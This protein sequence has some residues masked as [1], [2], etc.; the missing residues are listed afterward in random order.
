MGVAK[1]DLKRRL[2]PLYRPAAG[3]VELDVPAFPLLMVDG[4]G[5]P[6]T[7]PAWR[8]AVEA[9]YAVSYAVK[10]ALRR[11]H[12]LDYV[13]MPLEGLWWADDPA[14][15]LRGER[16]A[17]RWTAMIMQPP[18]AGA[19]LVAEAVAGVRAKKA[20]PAL[21]RLRLETFTEGRCAQVLHVGP[22]RD[23]GAAI[24]RLHAWI[25]E[26]STLRGRH[27]EIYLDD[28]RRSAPEKLRTLLRQP[29]A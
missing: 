10:F 22:Y 3:I 23:E 24:A 18:E 27:H 26:R 21:E 29:M 25:G 15:F 17:W 8:E 12:A 19:E 14:S 2:G 9:L 5:D 4:G 16:A 1:I 7:V 28:P 20:L 11:R 13:V 6:D